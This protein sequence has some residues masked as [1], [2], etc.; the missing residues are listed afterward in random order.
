MTYLNEYELIALIS[1]MCI[2][3]PLGRDKSDCKYVYEH[4]VKLNDMGVLSVFVVY[5]LLTSNQKQA[6]FIACY[7]S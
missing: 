2:F 5:L 6:M 3:G 4:P 7:T 1:E